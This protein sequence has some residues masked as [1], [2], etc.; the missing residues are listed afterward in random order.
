MGANHGR[1]S[2]FE[3]TGLGQLS[4]S[5]RKFREHGWKRPKGLIDHEVRDPK[6]LFLAEWQ[7]VERVGKDPRQ[8]KA[9]FQD[10]W[11]ISDT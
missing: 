10:A 9:V 5:K 4:H 11:A 2:A 8:I 1:R 6:S 3:K 7:Q